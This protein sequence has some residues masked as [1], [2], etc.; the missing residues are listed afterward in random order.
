MRMAGFWKATLALLAALAVV[1]AW[2]LVVTSPRNAED[3]LVEVTA[4]RFEVWSVYEGFLESH[5]VRDILSQLN[6]P[7]AIVELADDGSMARAGD[8][9][10]RFDGSTWER[11]LVRLERDRTLASED[12]KTLT[13]AKL[14]LELR[15]LEMRLA[16]A[17][18]HYS[19]DLD[20]L[21]DNRDLLRSGL[22]ATQE[23]AQQEMRAD[24]SR[25]T[26]AALEEQADLTRRYLHPAAIERA[27]AV[28]S[29]AEQEVGM[30]AKQV[31][32][33]VVRAPGDGMLGYKTISVGGEFRTVRIGDSVFKNQPFMTISDMS[34][35]VLRCDVPEAEL[36]RI[37]PGAPALVSPVACP[38]TPLKGSVAAVG[39]MAQSVAGK[40][41]M[42]KYF[43][44]VVRLEERNPLLR[45]G[46]SAQVRVLSYSNGAAL[47]LPR[48]AIWWEGET[49]YCERKRGRSVERVRL[50]LGM[51]NE[52]QIEVI[53]GV[54]AGDRVV[55]R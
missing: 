6:G 37:P 35:L 13:N 25:A 10:V 27:K 44:A 47:R 14:P 43:H 19:Q 42:Q 32:N 5:N 53:G 55:V 7:A 30:A 51:A 45:P 48:A 12:L 46:M 21:E 18:R 49:P 31:S 40:P 38:E 16:E 23:V 8:V 24:L 11:E 1:I 50:T 17:R 36:R 34:N 9:V 26:A 15:D 2:P 3:T 33:C 22:I 54:R 28:L 39:S 4:G 41:G 20:A 29:S 52:M